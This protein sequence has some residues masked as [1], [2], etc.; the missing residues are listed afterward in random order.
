MKRTIRLIHVSDNLNNILRTG[1]VLF[2]AVSVDQNLSIAE[3]SC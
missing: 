3:H 1:G 2:G